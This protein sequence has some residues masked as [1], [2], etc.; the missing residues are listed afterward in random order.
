MEKRSVVDV[1]GFDV[2]DLGYCEIR[3][4]KLLYVDGELLKREYHRTT[5]VPN[6]DV[7]ATLD[8]LNDHLGEMG[9]P[10]I[11]ANDRADIVAT[12]QRR[13]TE[14]RKANFEQAI[15]EQ[16]PSLEE[17]AKNDSEEEPA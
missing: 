7:E 17:G 2:S 15:A 3:I 1:I 12:T 11:S 6:S 8:A 9:Y 5:L 16:P 10:P 13:W 14:E 4:S